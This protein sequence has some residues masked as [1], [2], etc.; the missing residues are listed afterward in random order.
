MLD[1]FA[2]F[3]CRRLF[4]F[5]GLLDHPGGERCI[6]GSMGFGLDYSFRQQA[7]NRY[8]MVMLLDWSP[9]LTQAELEGAIEGILEQIWLSDVQDTSGDYE[10][11]RR[12][13]MVYLHVSP[14]RIPSQIG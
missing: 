2:V 1:F 8:V 12:G 4:G 3:L 14:R 7:Y 9:C 6:P 10:V 5:K 11:R 13:L